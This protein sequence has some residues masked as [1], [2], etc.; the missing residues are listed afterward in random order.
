MTKKLTTK[1]FLALGDK[2]TYEEL[3]E[4]LPGK[5]AKATGYIIYLKGY[6]DAMKFASEELDK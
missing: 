6:K 1:Q 2:M 5:E 4:H 3:I